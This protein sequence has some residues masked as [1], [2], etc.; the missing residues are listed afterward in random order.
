MDHHP[1]MT[2]E[3][4]PLQDGA[5]SQIRIRGPA[6]TI[7]AASDVRRLLAMLA[8]CSG[9]PVEV[10]LSVA[11]TN[12]DSCWAELWDHVLQEVPAA[13]AEI[14]FEVRGITPVAHIG[15]ER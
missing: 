1:R 14:R 6:I 15:H 3:L 10:A 8:F 7:L 11:G 4:R 12:A 13:H 2:M 5:Y 9:G